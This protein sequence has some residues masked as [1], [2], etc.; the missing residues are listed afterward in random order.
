MSALVCHGAAVSPQVGF[1]V[2][3]LANSYQLPTAW[4]VFFAWHVPGAR[5]SWWIHQGTSILWR[6]SKMRGFKCSLN[7]TELAQKVHVL[8]NPGDIPKILNH[9]ASFPIP[10]FRPKNVENGERFRK[11]TYLCH[12]RLVASW[13]YVIGLMVI[14]KAV[15]SLYAKPTVQRNRNPNLFGL[16][17]LPET[18][19]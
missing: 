10:F 6:R 8:N 17:T 1:S 14:Q 19:N 4:A 7:V 11:K 13:C 9:T 18:W 12:P 3:G 15:Q 16:M 2:S 5:P